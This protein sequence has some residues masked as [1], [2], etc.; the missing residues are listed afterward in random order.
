MSTPKI[1]NK[2]LINYANLKIEQH[3]DGNQDQ[4]QV[5]FI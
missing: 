2:N 4:G 5:L 1:I 3:N